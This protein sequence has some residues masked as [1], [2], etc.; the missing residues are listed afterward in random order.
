MPVDLV[1]CLKVIV[2]YACICAA[3]HAFSFSAFS[4]RLKAFV[5]KDKVAFSNR[6]VSTLHAVVMFSMAVKYWLFI[7]PDMQL[8]ELVDEYQAFCVQV[9]L[10]YL[11]Y[12][13]IF[14]LTAG[15]QIM[16]LGHHILGGAS[17]ISVLYSNHGATGFYR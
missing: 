15:K 3:V 13:T 9:M 2:P 4:G 6:M 8:G 5:K 12:D 14:E 16:T 10:G 7:N 17:H 11:L 1:S